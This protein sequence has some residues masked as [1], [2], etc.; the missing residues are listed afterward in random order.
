MPRLDQL[1]LR[2]PRVITGFPDADP[3]L[4]A[5]LLEM[6][7]D[8]G[9]TVEVTDRAA[10]GDPLAVRIGATKVALRR[11]IARRIETQ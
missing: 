5:R 2:Q 8:E 4:V 6:G 1:P 11:A 10:G 3:P 7:F 9:V